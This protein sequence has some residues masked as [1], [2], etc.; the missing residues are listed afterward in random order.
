MVKQPHTCGT[1]EVRH[2]HPQ[3][4]ARFLGCRIMSI[5]W[6]QSDI[7]VA[8]LIKVIHSL[9]TYRVHYSKDW[10]AK[11]H[12]LALLWRDWR[13]SDT[14]V[15]RLLNAISYFN[16][17]IRCIIDSCDQWL[18]NEKGQYY[19]MLKRVFWCFPQC[20][21]GF[22]HCRPIVSVD[23]I[24]LI[25]KYKSTLMVAVGM[26]AE[27][28]L[29]PLAFALIDGENNESWSW[30]LCLVR[31]EVLGPD[32]S[33]CMISDHHHG[34]LNGAKDPIDGYPP[35]IHR[36][37]SR[38]FATNIW[39]KQRSKEVIARLKAL[40]KVKKEKKFED[41]LKEMEKILNDDANA[42]LL[43]QWPEKSKWTLAFDE[44][45]SRYGIMATNISEVFNFVLKGIRALSISGIVDYTFHKCNEYFVNRWNKA[46][47]SIAKGEHWGEHAR[48][49]LLEQCKIPTNEVVMLF[50]PVR[51]V[52]EVKSSSRTNVS[53]EIS[54]GRIFRVEIGDVVSC[55]CMTPTLLH[56]PC[57]HVITACR[58]RHVLHEGSNQMSPYYSLSIEEKTWAARFESLLDP[59]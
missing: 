25:G 31:K 53:G 11:E 49:H 43:Q 50:D 34:L 40:C 59:S 52:Y 33:I 12:T 8:A 42:W 10:G 54:G 17:G 35:L 22:A 16:P 20:V 36:W 32:R 48:K 28:Q 58:M 2:V 5:M 51:L 29:P 18:P 23:A 14:K 27:N 47:Q 39:K 30:F 3:C 41:K 21:G 19:P 45:G 55:T 15:P 24:F 4:T 38:H 26:T 56:L 57:S 44:G 13:E 6:A 37:C 46:R 9:T 7:T 1:S